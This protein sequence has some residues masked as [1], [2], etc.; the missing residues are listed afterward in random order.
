MIPSKLYKRIVESVPIVCVDVILRYKD[1]YLLVFRNNE[2]LKDKWWLVGGRA[3]KGERTIDTAKRKVREETGLTATK[4]KMRGVY[5]DSYPR[6][7]WGVPT[8]SVSIVYEAQVKVFK[9][10]LD[11]TSSSISAMKKLP[12][13]FIKHYEKAN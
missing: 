3:L 4:F 2:P 13:R 1:K 8:S 5:E 9:P 11:K 10:K 12:D 6:S 7:A